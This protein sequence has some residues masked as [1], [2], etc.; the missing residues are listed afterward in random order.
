MVHRLKEK[1]VLVT[2]GASGIGRASTERLIA[3]GARVVIA[4]LNERMGKATVD[5]MPAGS[6]HFI[7]C[8]V[9]DDASVRQL[10]DDAVSWLGG[11]DVLVNNAGI[12]VCKPLSE[13][14]A[15][16]WDKVFAVNTKGAFLT[17]RYAIAHMRSGGGGSIINMSSLAGQRGMPGLTLYSATKAALVGLSATLAIELAPDKIRVNA[18][19]PGWI[20]TPFNQAVIDALGGPEAQ[21]QAIASGIPL[22]RMGK[23][24]EIAA[25]VAYL[26][27]DDSA[28]MTAQALAING[29]AY[30]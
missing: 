25:A 28:F 20:D 16:T 21:A 3:E 1:T 13:L 2:G 8:D 10:L 11:L 30:N 24:E 27:S 6:A 19:C 14:D 7:K 5:A 29:G 15:E 4:D 26:A 23:I 9:S 12:L 18:I 17:C 22:G